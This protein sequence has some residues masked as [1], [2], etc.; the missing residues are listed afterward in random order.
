VLVLS[1]MAVHAKGLRCPACGLHLVGVE[2]LREAGIEAVRSLGA[3]TAD[4]MQ[5]FGLGDVIELETDE[6]PDAED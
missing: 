6:D 3:P 4:D 2:E 1:E 5:A